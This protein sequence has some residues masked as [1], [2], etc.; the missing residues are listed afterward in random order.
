MEKLKILVADSQVVVKQHLLQEL[1]KDRQIEII[2]TAGNGKEAYEIFEREDP[3][4]I[5]F[6]L[7]LPIY[8]GYTLLDKMNEHGVSNEQ[9]LIMTT[10]ITSDLLVSEAFH[11]GVDYVLTKPY[12]A[13]IVANKIRTLY[14]RMNRSRPARTVKTDE[15]IGR[16]R[17]SE[18][19]GRYGIKELETTYHE[20]DEMISKRLNE[21]GIP[22]R[23]KGYRYIITAIKRV[24]ENDEALESVT[25]ILYPDVAKKHNST[26]QRV[27]KAIRHAIEVAWSTDGDQPAHK[28][29]QYIISPGKSRPTNSEFIAKMAQD[30]KLIYNKNILEGE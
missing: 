29:F 19:T 28:E 15:N 9:K 14:E 21:I 3:N 5:I 24:I 27:E 2:G 16:I 13:T 4:I 10:P 17:E 1:K 8:D 6:D 7:L 11:Q 18:I 25:K 30:I 26:A 12:D 20:L 23:L 22:A